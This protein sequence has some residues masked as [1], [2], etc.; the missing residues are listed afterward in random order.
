MSQVEKLTDGANGLEVAT[1]NGGDARLLDDVGSD[2]T[3]M[4]GPA[5]DNTIWKHP[6]LRALS[7][8]LQF[9][10][11][12]FALLLVP[13]LAIQSKSFDSD[14]DIWWHIRVGD[15]IAEHHA[16]PR[17]GIFS[18]HIERPWTAYSW[19]FDLLVSGVQR[20]FGLAGIP[21]LM[22]CLEILISLTFLLS[23]RRVAGT[24]WWS[25]VIG[26]AGILALYID[27]PRPG[28]LTLLFFT[29]ELFLIFH[30]EQRGDDKLLYWLAPLFLIWANCHI[31]FIYGIA[32]L[33][34]YLGSRIV[35]A[36]LIHTSDGKTY[37]SS[38]VPQLIGVFAIA[39]LGACIGPNGWL[40]YK[41]ALA[42]A[43]QRYI[44]Q[45]IQEMTAM[46]FRRPEHYLELILVMTACFALGRSR[47]RDLFRPALLLMTAMISF[48]SLRD[49]WFAAMAASFVIA[50]WIRERPKPQPENPAV[51]WR[52]EP[53]GYVLA[54]LLAVVLSFGYGLRHGISFADMISEIDRVYPIRAT[55]FIRDSNLPGPMYNDFDWGGFLIFNLPDRP[56]SIDPRNDMYGDELL[57]RS[58]GTANGIR[59]QSDPDLTRSNLVILNRHLA[60]A[61]EL[62]RDADYRLVYQD[63][64]AT[65]FVRQP[66]TR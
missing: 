47:R 19:C 33:G 17:F 14:A 13:Y 58:I 5:P 62:Q 65:V 50:E 53:V 38:S 32:V 48:R 1:Q 21:R 43:Q 24:F 15:W 55:E 7:R 9:A 39:A 6:T 41:V 57:G 37:C 18:Q 3:R 63:Q 60:L 2:L 23:I 42:Y 51:S 16:L 29:L 54:A 59:W 66:N 34:T 49:M 30:S 8:I 46:S 10:A 11:A 20:V 44:Y 35:S 12:T 27:A 45:L 40:P 28:L 22:I 56:V 31:Q 36:L 26:S 25:W 64:L 52:W 61:S 4:P